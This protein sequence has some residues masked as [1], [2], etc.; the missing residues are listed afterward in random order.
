MATTRALSKLCSAISTRLRPSSSPTPSTAALAWFAAR[1]TSPPTQ[2]NRAYITK[3][4]R[5][6]GILLTKRPREP[7]A[8][9]ATANHA[10]S[11]GFAPPDPP[12]NPTL[13]RC[14]NVILR[15]L[16]GSYA[17]RT[18]TAKRGKPMPTIGS[19]RLLQI[20]VNSRPELMR[21]ALRRAGAIGKGELVEWVSPLDS[22][23]HREYRDRAALHRLRLYSKLHQPLSSFW[24]SR[25][26]VWDGLAV[27]AKETPLLVEAKA[28][29][30]EAASP[31][32]KATPASRKLID[33]SL[34]AARHHLAPRSKA[35]WG[36]LFYQYANRLAFQFFLRRNNRIDSHLV[37][38]D[39]TNAT[40]V[41]GPASEEEW[42]GAIRRIHAVLGLPPDLTSFGVYKAFID[43]RL[44]ADAA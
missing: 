37:F 7:K 31:A 9:S 32:S 25:G 4:P 27:I 16:I 18:A 20:A 3:R 17:D 19:Q 43:A 33:A 15:R 23:G 10:K 34:A 38:L 11:Q 42:H 39:F 41:N 12:E 24:P 6:D 30:P 29:I 22:E 13:R 36:E 1:S 8:P 40:D 2:A 28:H 5:A 21:S 14:A 35:I 44:L 26:A